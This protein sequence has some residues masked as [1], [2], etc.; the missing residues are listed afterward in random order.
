MIDRNRAERIVRVI[1]PNARYDSAHRP[2]PMLEELI[3]ILHYRD[4]VAQFVSRNIKVRYKR[5][6]LGVA[7]TMLNPLLMMTILTL[8]FSNIFRVSVEHYPIYVLSGLIL[9]NFFGFTTIVAMNEL[10]FGG[11]LFHRIYVPR[12]VFAVSAT[13]SGLLNLVLAL[14]PLL[15]IMLVTGSVPTVALL[16]LPVAILLM[17]MFTLGVSLF[18]SALAA[19]FG[20]MLDIHQIVLS[21]WMYLTPIIYPVEIVPSQYRWLL[22]LNPM[23]HLLACFR[24]PIYAGVLPSGEQFLAAAISATVALVVGWWFFANRADE[25]AYRI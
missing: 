25:L 8:V 3:G 22:N 18:L 12:T 5:S 10:V 21:A 9:W 15:L 24:A 4:L 7:W 23:Y 16:F 11:N 6:V 1:P 17:A 19:Y 14:V 2:P 13:G 20:D